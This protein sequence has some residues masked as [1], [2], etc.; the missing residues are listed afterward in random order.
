MK[1]A[2]PQR[3]D[4][5]FTLVEVMVAALLIGGALLTIV[6]ASAAGFGFQISARQ[7]LVANGIASRVMEQ[8]RSL[9]FDRV[10]QGLP[11]S[12]SPTTLPACG[13][14]PMVGLGEPLVKGSGL[15]DAVGLQPNSS[16]TP[17][18]VNG[19]DF[20]WTSYVSR[21]TSGSTPNPP[22]RVTVCV[23]WPS[24][25][26]LQRTSL[27]SLFWTPA[28]T[29]PDTGGSIAG[30]WAIGEAVVP[31]GS[32]TVDYWPS[33]VS[34]AS[35]DTTL[36]TS[37][38]TFGI[39]GARAVGSFSD[40][41]SMEASVTLPTPSNAFTC[42]LVDGTNDCT[43]AD[44]RLEVLA[45]S[46]SGATP[47]AA[48][49][50][51]LCDYF[52]AS[53]SPL[54]VTFQAIGAS[55]IAVDAKASGSGCTVIAPLVGSAGAPCATAVSTRG[56]SV[57]YNGLTL[58]LAVPGYGDL[59]ALQFT[60]IRFGATVRGSGTNVKPEAVRKF[61]L[62]RFA[63]LGS[64]PVLE[65]AYGDSAYVVGQSSTSATVDTWNTRA[66][67]SPSTCSLSGPTSLSNPADNTIGTSYCWRSGVALPHYQFSGTLYWLSPVRFQTPG[68]A[69]SPHTSQ[70][71]GPSITVTLRV[72]KCIN[73]DNLC[74]T[75]SGGSPSSRDVF[76]GTYRIRVA[77]GAITASYQWL[78]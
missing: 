51:T 37:R 57:V 66:Y 35:I 23:T 64:S 46:A 48:T 45:D 11:S 20:T 12:F 19:T 55:D 78:Q 36:P 34:D 47:T 74:S 3:G 39:T 69:A 54:G 68:A 44:S 60:P 77:L 1:P 41:T 26:G 5:G 25:K 59:T 31:E 70:V 62:I 17:V 30:P 13:S 32:V 18:M 49:C 67:S 73:S 22:F 4:A 16:G 56:A 7:R 61:E 2:P 50:G 9:P 71:S 72:S 75:F 38:F 76:I 8:I 24:S 52:L 29:G 65:V 63:I 28:G 58:N 33:P 27:Q 42:T 53:T 6:T 14:G 21:L 40:A 10:K 15:T 43:L